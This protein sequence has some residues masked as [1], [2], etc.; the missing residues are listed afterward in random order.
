MLLSMECWWIYWH[1]IKE[2]CW[3]RKTWE[4]NGWKHVLHHYKFWDNENSSSI[5]RH[6]T[7]QNGLPVVKKGKNSDF[8]T[9]SP[10]LQPKSQHWFN[11]ISADLRWFTKLQSP[12]EGCSKDCW[13]TKKVSREESSKASLAQQRMRMTKIRLWS[14]RDENSTNTYFILPGVLLWV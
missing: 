14:L 7:S 4:G 12:A 9:H 8:L 2:Y 1:T 10:I 13:V 3:I 11:W 5:S 6:V